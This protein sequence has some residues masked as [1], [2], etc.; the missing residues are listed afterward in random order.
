MKIDVASQIGAVTREVGTRQ[1]N[2]R[3][4]RLVVASRTYNT[5]VEDVWMR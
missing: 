2:G 4:A 3:P 1:H 5:T